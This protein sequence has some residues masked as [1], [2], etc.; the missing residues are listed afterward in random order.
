MNAD[1]FAAGPV[2]PQRPLRVPSV[3]LPLRTWLSLLAAGIAMLLL[4]AFVQAVRLAVLQGDLRLRSNA[5][6]LEAAWRC[7]T[8]RGRERRDACRARIADVPRDSALLV[9][10]DGTVPASATFNP[11]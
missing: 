3:R 7:N 2:R 11:P 8:I 9:S 1:P 5:R 10:F 4:V 6:Q